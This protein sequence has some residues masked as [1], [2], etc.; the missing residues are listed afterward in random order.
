MFHFSSV[1]PLA[2]QYRRALLDDVLPFW[3]RHSPDRECGGYFTCLDRC[4]NVYDADKFVW[5]QG[6]QAWTFAALYNRLEKREAWLRLSELGIRF[7]ERHG[8]DAEGNFYFALNRQG[9]PLIAA[10]NIFSDCF[11][12]M[13]FS[14]Y[15]LAAGDEHAKEIALAAYRNIWKRRENP[16]GRFSKAGAKARN[17]KTLVLPMIHINLTA[18]LEWLL[19][20]A[21]RERVLDVCLHEV[22]D[23]CRDRKRSLVFA[24]VNPDG[25][26]PDCLDWY[27]QVHEYAWSRFPDPE[28]GEW[29]GYL[30]RRGEVLLPLKGGKWKGC[31]HL[32]RSLYLCLKEFQRCA[33]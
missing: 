2:A 28:Y 6:R 15:A 13:A 30:N 25:A 27:R 10:Y 26:H 4:G 23:L 33:V 12:A 5:L 20:E 1:A 8:R 22:I 3:E 21:E 16:K 24:S 19:P 14:Q 11:A 18:E 7:L 32:P 29:W 31:F 17:L 9:E